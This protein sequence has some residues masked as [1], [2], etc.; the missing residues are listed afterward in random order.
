VGNE[1][2]HQG[3]R[4]G[5]GGDLVAHHR[6]HAAVQPGAGG[7]GVAVGGEQ[8]VLRADLSARCADAVA[9]AVAFGALHAGVAE[10]RRP[11]GA[12]G[13]AQRPVQFG[14][15]QA[16]VILDHEAAVEIVAADLAVLLGA[17]QDFDGH[18]GALVQRGG[19]GVQRGKVGGAEGA[20]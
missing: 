5:L 18:A 1:L 2:V 8:H 16:A 10:Q 20:E 3:A 19:V 12:R 6:Q 15:V 4:Q 17:R 14:R 7:V 9:V 11:R 13:L